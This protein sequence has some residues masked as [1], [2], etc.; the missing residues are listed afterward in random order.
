MSRWGKGLVIL[1]IL[2]SM[3]MGGLVGRAIYKQGLDGVLQ[4]SSKNSW[5]L[6]SFS[7]P[8][9]GM[10]PTL[11]AGDILL[12]DMYYYKYQQPAHD[13]VAIYY[14]PVSGETFISRIVGLPG[15][16][17]AIKGHRLVRNGE[18]VSE[19]YIYIQ[20]NDNGV[21]ANRRETTVPPGRLYML[22]DNRANAIDS[23]FAAFHGYVPIKNL[24]GKAKWI[25]WGRSLSRFGV[26]V[27]GPYE[28]N[29]AAWSKARQ[30]CAPFR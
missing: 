14:N 1:S 30:S 3:L 20:P 6:R 15:D 4:K 28:V 22:S 11:L 29:S 8:S 10:C 18:P 2:F 13:E 7:I 26:G 21:A 24:M 17:I 9:K 27:Q 25:Y 5:G 23:R 16:R 19:P 12:A